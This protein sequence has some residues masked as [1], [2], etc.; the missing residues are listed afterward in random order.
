MSPISVMGLGQEMNWARGKVAEWV[1]G[2]KARS[3][4]RRPLSYYQLS[5][6]LSDF[7]CTLL[8][9]ILEPSVGGD[10]VSQSAHRGGEAV[11]VSARP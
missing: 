9:I 1:W 5:F 11:C 7:F 4:V 3:S 6:S 2:K 8:C 10:V